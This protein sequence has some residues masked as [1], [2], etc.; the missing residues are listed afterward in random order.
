MT[1]EADQTDLEAV[2]RAVDEVAAR[3]GR[4]DVLMLPVDGEEHIL[5]YDA[6][7]RILEELRP[8]YVV[9]MH[10][11]IP[12]LEPGDGPSD[13]GPID[14]WLEG[15]EGVRRLRSNVWRVGDGG[16]GDGGV[17]V[18]QPSPAVPRPGGR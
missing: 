15:R 16:D 1:V 8:R 4:I 6:V 9:P 11:R 7:D 2:D 3:M 5:T 18:F 13:L 14:P 12:E 17:V 10:Y